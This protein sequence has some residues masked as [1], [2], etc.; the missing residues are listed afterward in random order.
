MEPNFNINRPKVSDEEI[1]SRKNFDELVN[2][3]KQQSIEKAKKD[4]RWPRLRKITYGTVIAGVAVVCT[5]TISNIKTETNDDKTTTHLT[6]KYTQTLSEN[7]PKNFIH[8][9][10]KKLTVPYSTY[11]VNAHKG[12]TITHPSSSK[13]TV[14]KGAFVKKNGMD[15]KGEVEI[16]YREMH[17]PVD[18][19]LSGIPMVYDSAGQQF[20]F[21]TAGMVDIK[22]FQD[23]EPIYI[24]PGKTLNV[25][26]ASKQEGTHYNLYELD[27]VAKKWQLKG[28]DKVVAVGHEPAANH[29]AVVASDPVV[30]KIEKQIGQVM[31]DKENA[32]TV[33][34]SKIA[35]LPK[36][37][38]PTKPQ[39]AAGDRKKFK[40][41]VDYS[42]FPEL[43]AY[44]NSVFEVGK[45]N[46]NYTPEFNQIEWNE[47]FITPGTDPGK[48]YTLNLRD[49][50]RKEK[51]IV[52]PVLEGENLKNA[53]KKY[54]SLFTEYTASLNKRTA[55]ENR[56][57]QELD[58]KIKAF[59][60]EQ[61]RLTRLMDEQRNR[62]KNEALAGMKSASGDMDVKVRRI[63]D[64]SNFGV[65]NTDCPRSKP[66]GVTVDAQFACGNTLLQP[67]FV[68]L[69][70]YGKNTVFN[71]SFNQ[72]ENF[73]YNP[74]EE[75][76]I[77]A[78]VNNK[79]FWCGKDAFKNAK[80]NQDKTTFEFEDITFATA[81]NEELRKKLG[82]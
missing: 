66:Q 43:K 27:T 10:S 14:P 51:L 70:P 4:N 72:F 64:V 52:Y 61:A 76:Y 63:F 65:H 68:Y 41:E 16:H 7:N 6:H 50:T 19:M 34:N 44:K 21:E 5:V 54:E 22:G 12:G 58:A 62:A 15:V 48:N 67:G 1:E 36:P 8:P 73:S 29:A 47:A 40:L 55:E 13:I 33:T 57:K 17:D 23:G 79:L 82:V 74:Q 35:A 53:Q 39:V 20:H 42:E 71:Y 3:F 59:E 56:L 77:I 30:E 18:V 45:E 75:Y 69:I 37:V 31:V 2:K 49:G 28:K 25:D 60:Q 78:T 24:K 11:K 26:L 80:P 9:I 38:E 46:K 32:V 81:D